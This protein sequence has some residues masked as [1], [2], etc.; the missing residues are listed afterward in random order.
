[1]SL[2]GIP[3][4]SLGLGVVNFSNLPDLKVPAAQ[5]YRDY[6]INFLEHSR[7]RK[8]RNRGTAFGIVHNWTGLTEG[9]KNM[10]E[11]PLYYAPDMATLNQVKL[12]V[13]DEEDQFLL[14]KAHGE[15]NRIVAND[16]RLYTKD[17]TRPI[18]HSI[19]V[20][21]ACYASN[22][23]N[24]NS[25]A[26]G[27]VA[28]GATSVVGH[29]SETIYFQHMRINFDL[30]KGATIGDAWRASIN[31]T[32]NTSSDPRTQRCMFEGIGTNPTWNS[33]ATESSSIV[34]GDPTNQFIGR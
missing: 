27:F 17:L 8:G 13:F 5:L 24:S 9:L 20:F 14:I 12:S 11:P 4:L 3:N 31:D 25:F 22:I 33:C 1:V 15:Q 21:A 19:V 7:G 10:A 16:G 23:M 30:D 34:F 6:A 28:K 18:R 26:M 2:S 29:G 32:W